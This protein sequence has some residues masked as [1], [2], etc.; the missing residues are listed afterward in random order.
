MSEKQ[1]DLDSP[2][3]QYGKAAEGLEP[4]A[5]GDATSR[6]SAFE[7]ADQMSEGGEGPF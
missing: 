5:Y 1:E 3:D 4:E 6:I 2:D 7:D